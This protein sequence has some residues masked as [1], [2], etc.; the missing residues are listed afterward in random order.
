VRSRPRYGA[1]ALLVVWRIDHCDPELL[2]GREVDLSPHQVE[3]HDECPLRKVGLRPDARSHRL[4]VLVRS[5]FAS[6]TGC[7]GGNSIGTEFPRSTPP[8][9]VSSHV[10]VRRARR[11]TARSPAPSRVIEQGPGGADCRAISHQL[12]AMARG[13]DRDRGPASRCTAQTR[14]RV[15]AERRN[16]PQSAVV[17][18][19][20][21][22]ERTVSPLLS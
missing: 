12:T 15:R 5:S 3:D 10:Q 13:R 6:I 1:S 16:P 19:S 14:A 20:H 22:V 18:I 2:A 4:Y 8:A 9:S 21:S 11:S 17:L 7:C